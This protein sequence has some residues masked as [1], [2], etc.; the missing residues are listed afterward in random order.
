MTVGLVRT[1]GRLLNEAMGIMP[2]LR[3][4]PRMSVKG[5]VDQLLDELVV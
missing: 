1:L 5:V 3:R 2:L 4:C